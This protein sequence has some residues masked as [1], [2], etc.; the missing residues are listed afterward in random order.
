MSIDRKAAIAAYKE[1]KTAV[2]IYVVRCVATGEAWVGQAFD[3]EKVANRIWFTLR[4][5]G[6]PCRALQAAWN[7]HGAAGLT[8]AECE[9]LDEEETSYIRDAL[10]KDRMLHWRSDLN[11]EAI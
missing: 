5:G 2:G 10:L 9:R 1:R 11:A 4:Q 8:F 3:L 7:A 6:H